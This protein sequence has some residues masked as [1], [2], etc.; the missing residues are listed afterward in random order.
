MRTNLALSRALLLIFLF[1]LIASAEPAEREWEPLTSRDYWLDAGLAAGAFAAYN[2]IEQQDSDIGHA[3]FLDDAGR[4][5]FRF[6]SAGRRRDADAWSNVFLVGAIAIPVALDT[7]LVWSRDGNARSAAR[8]SNIN[9]QAM[10]LTAILTGT[11]KA[12]I[13]RERPYVTECRRNPGSDPGCRDLD[14]EEGAKSFY[15]GH[16][17]YAFT[18]AGLACLHHTQLRLYGDYRDRVACGSAIGFAS[19]VALLR[20][21]ADKHYVTDVSTGAL[22]G[23]MAGYVFPRWLHYT[24]PADSRENVR[25]VNAFWMPL[26]ADDN[27]YGI[28]RLI[29]F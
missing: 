17:V 8:I 15:S 23:L 10:G 4:S 5:A 22:I 1:P 25:K 16:A 2:L 26:I 6:S 27:T 9:A 18:G 28:A 13:G 7:L 14:H 21:G 11:T 29:Y 19:V 20:V 12:L 24:R 3:N